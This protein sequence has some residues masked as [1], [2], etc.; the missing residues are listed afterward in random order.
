MYSLFV[1]ESGIETKSFSSLYLGV[2]I[3]NKIG[4]KDGKPSVTI[5]Q[6]LAKASLQSEV[7]K[8][9]YCSMEISFLSP[10]FLTTS[11]TLFYIWTSSFKIFVMV[12]INLVI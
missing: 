7:L 6:N 5:F 9:L 12:Y 3:A 1:R 8:S 2:L 10:R 11:V 4:L